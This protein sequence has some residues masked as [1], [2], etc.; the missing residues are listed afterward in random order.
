MHRRAQSS[1]HRVILLCMEVSNDNIT[2]TIINQQ[3]DYAII[4]TN[5]VWNPKILVGEQRYRYIVFQVT[6]L[7][8]GGGGSIVSVWDLDIGFQ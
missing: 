5:N 4:G 2:Y 3:T 7:K 1:P 8:E 6:K